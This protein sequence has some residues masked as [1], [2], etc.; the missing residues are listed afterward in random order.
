M[1]A[2]DTATRLRAQQASNQSAGQKRV[3]GTRYRMAA[4]Q[5][6]QDATKIAQELDA[7]ARSEEISLRHGNQSMTAQPALQTPP[8]AFTQVGGQ[9]SMSEESPEDHVRGL[10]KS[11][12]LSSYANDADHRASMSGRAAMGVSV[13]EQEN[14]IKENMIGLIDQ[15]FDVF[16]NCAYE[17]NKFA[18]GTELELNWIRPFLSKEG[19]PTQHS[20][21]NNLVVIF[22]GRMST[23]RWTMVIKG[24]LEYIQVFI[25]PADKLIGFALSTSNFRPFFM[26]EPA[27]EGL[28]VSWHINRSPLRREMFP[29]IQRELFNGLIRHA[30]GEIEENE[31][32]DLE[33]LGLAP[34]PADPVVDQETQRYYQEAFIEDINASMNGTYQSKPIASRLH[35]NIQVPPEAKENNSKDFNEPLPSHIKRELELLT[36][37]ANPMAPDPRYSQ[38]T[39]PE[40]GAPQA[41]QA[42][43]GPRTANINFSNASHVNMPDFQAAAAKIRLEQEKATRPVPGAANGEQ[44]MSNLGNAAGVIPPPAQT[45][46]QQQQQQQQRPAPMATPAPVAPPNGPMNLPAALSILLMSIDKELEVVA[47]AGADA[48]NSKEFARADAALKFS[49]RLNDYRKVS[50]EL[51]DYYRRKR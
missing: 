1:S 36:Q 7:I 6:P 38:N 49:A 45:L 11:R 50:Q 48:F 16:Q 27:C 20:T 41:V 46:Q 26:M 12:V 4:A 44:V 40:P 29:V 30:T 8:M 15:M 51:L 25:L 42:A 9:Q 34:A 35:E 10:W 23:R 18:T 13:H 33:L 32:F 28:N 14:A 5:V 17:M 2:K 43:Q 21:D 3:G 19:I 24:T 47:K 37:G 31:C 39:S 22:S